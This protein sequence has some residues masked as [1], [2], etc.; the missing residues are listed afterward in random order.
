VSDKTAITFRY[1]MMRSVAQGTLE[2]AAHTFL[3][4]IAVRWFEAGANAKA[5]VAASGSFGLLIS[6][7]VVSRVEHIGCRVSKAAATILAMGA[8]SLVVMALFPSLP[9]YVLGSIVAMASSSASIPLMTQIYQEN[10]PGKERGRRFSRTVIIRIM[11]AAV[12][13]YLAGKMLDADIERFRLLLII[14]AGAFAFSS[15][16]VSRIPSQ[17]L[18]VS[19]GTH[20]LRALKFVKTDPLFRLTLIAWMFMGFG[21][22]MMFPMRV[23]YLANP[24]YQLG[25]EVGTVA[26]IVGVVPN[27]ARLITSAMWGWLFDHMNFFVLRVILNIGFAIGIGVYFHSSTV[28]GLVIGAILF[29]VSHAGGDVAWSLWVTKFAPP[30]RVADYMSTHTF[31]TGVRGALGPIVGFSLV[32]SMGLPKL[33]LLSIAFIAISIVLLVKEIPAGRKGR[34]ES[35][36]NEDVSE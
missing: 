22:L 33:S 34:H 21:N 16:C 18:H 23:D 32:S 8:V 10:Y 7:V 27:V 31:F 3:L 12:F 17:P 15:F 13:S 20:P 2:T 30:E 25:L 26:L 35:A 36:L 1:E 6:P 29:G 14:F 11:S 9:V 24:D 4:L 28:P 19:G 5:L